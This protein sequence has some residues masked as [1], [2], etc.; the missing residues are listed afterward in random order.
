MV[1]S[2]RWGKSNPFSELHRTN[3]PGYLCIFDIDGVYTKDGM[4]EGIYEGK[5]KMYSQDRG[6]FIDDFYSEKN[7][8]S[9]CIQKMSHKIPVWISEESTN[10][11]WVVKGSKIEK[12]EKNNL[13]YIDTSDR[14]YVG[15]RLSKFSN[16]NKI[17]S[18]FHRTL[19]EKPPRDNE[20]TS[21]LSKLFGVKKI[22]VNDTIPDRIYMK[23]YLM[24]SFIEAPASSGSDWIDQ[25]KELNLI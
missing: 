10:T 11:W 19:G 7:I 4:I 22:L 24:E 16:S 8:Q 21:G 2:R 23:N 6:N 9:Q 5:Y 1:I 13:D 12:T 14:I 20:I 17:Y 15:Y 18:I 3:I 25:W